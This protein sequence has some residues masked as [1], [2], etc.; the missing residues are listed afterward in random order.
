MLAGLNFNPTQPNQLF[1]GLNCRKNNCYAVHTGFSTYSSIN[2][3][4]IGYIYS[5]VG[6]EYTVYSQAEIKSIKGIG[7]V[8]IEYTPLKKV[9]MTRILVTV[10][11]QP[12]LL[13]THNNHYDY[14]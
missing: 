4:N 14:R 13:N 3:I 11:L 2:Q 5:I 12:Q 6:I 9:S 10:I 7:I 1:N 8:G